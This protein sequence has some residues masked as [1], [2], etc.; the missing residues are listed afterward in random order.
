MKNDKVQKLIKEKLSDKIR[1]KALCEAIES[2]VINEG[3]WDSLKNMI[4]GKD[5]EKADKVSPAVRRSLNM[6]ADK[7]VKNMFQQFEKDYPKY[8]NIKNS[9]DF[10]KGTTTLG[11]M[12]KSVYDSAMNGQLPPEVANSIISSL[13]QYVEALQGDLSKTYKV[14][15]EEEEPID[16]DVGP[17]TAAAL[18]TAGGA[19]IA[20]PGGVGAVAGATASGIGTAA[21][22]FAGL[23]QGAAGGVGTLASWFGGTA[24]T[25]GGVLA[26]LGAIGAPLAVGAGAVMVGKYLLGSSRKGMLKKLSKLMK[27]VDIEKAVPYS[28]ARAEVATSVARASSAG[29]FKQA[30]AGYVQM[31]ET[32]AQ[33]GAEQ[34]QQDEGALRSTAGALEEAIGEENAQAFMQVASGQKEL[35]ELPD[36]QRQMIESL[37][38]QFQTGATE[39]NVERAVN[40]AETQVEMEQTI[41]DSESTDSDE[42][43]SE[44]PS[45]DQES[46]KDTPLS[47]TKTS[48]E[49]EKNIQ[50]VIVDMGLS[51]EVAGALANKISDY[52]T[53]RNMPVAEANLNKIANKFARNL[54]E[55]TAAEKKAQEDEAYRQKAAQDAA[56]AQTPPPPGDGDPPEGGAAARQQAQ[57]A[58]A[59]RVRD[60]QPQADQEKSI[61]DKAEV[62]LDA[63]NLLGMTGIGAAIATPAALG[64][65]ILHAG[66]GEWGK[67]AID[68]IAALPIA[69]SYFKGIVMAGKAG[70]LT[71]GLARTAKAIEA[72]KGTTAMAKA[73]QTAASI[74]NLTAAGVSMM[75]P[76]TQADLRNQLLGVSKIL[77]KAG[78][79]DA[80]SKIQAWT[81]QNLSA[82]SQPSID[83]PP[84]KDRT[85][86][87]GPGTTDSER[88]AA[89]AKAEVEQGKS[90][91]GKVIVR[92]LQ[93]DLESLIARD[94]EAAKFFGDPQKL[95]SFV[96]NLVTALTKQM[97]DRGYSDEDVGAILQEM[98]KRYNNKIL[99]RKTV[100]RWK[101]LYNST[102]AK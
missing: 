98:V 95:K 80:S 41:E 10:E 79:G 29:D 18:G 5:G 47:V 87:S 83:M 34:L 74:E 94:E 102:G 73:A 51:P 13:K 31:R 61:G 24:M 76:D 30:N 93:G 81:Q 28:G 70:K 26:A 78:M 57:A 22:W 63:A 90:A 2:G 17:R 14:F 4:G 82:Q 12:Y 11:I 97:S 68:L 75:E 86:S 69:G 58:A 44:D 42:T 59:A 35:S 6:A 96:T 52:M 71:G 55:L 56:A 39:E 15:K 43:D 45:A 25:G 66:R 50:D 91:V 99:E 40:V 8:P 36:S 38:S 23:V 53:K 37:L 62:V 85:G 33:A 72:A 7:T 54:M 100:N 77:N 1:E 65:L 67:A 84:A 3:I 20:T 89:V 48:R 92:A 88:A 27:P 60:Q 32:Y 21:S 16:E 64:S 46:G 101:E 19:T 9:K 49:G